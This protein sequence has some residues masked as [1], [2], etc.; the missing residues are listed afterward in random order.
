MVLWIKINQIFLWS[1]TRLYL[2]VSFSKIIVYTEPGD[3]DSKHGYIIAS[4]H[5]NRFDPFAISAALPFSVFIKLYPIHFMAYWQ[6]FSIPLLRWSLRSWGCF[7]TKPTRG[8]SYGLPHALDA[9]A[10]RQAVFIFPEGRR[11]PHGKGEAHHGVSVMAAVEG[12]EVLPCHIEWRRFGLLPSA[13]IV[14]G[15][16]APMKNVPPEDIV[17]NLHALS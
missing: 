1:I 6:F 12:A 10:N 2:F 3:F 13:R 16:P 17:A 15:K 4:N 8:L 11:V 14:I 7:P 9:L 5:R